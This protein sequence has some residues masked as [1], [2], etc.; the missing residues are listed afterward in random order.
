MNGKLMGTRGEDL[1]GILG[2]VSKLMGKR[3]ED[4]GGEL[5]LV[6]KLMGTTEEPLELLPMQGEAI[7]NGDGGG[8]M[9]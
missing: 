4:L 2:L 1:G 5:G 9:T 7:D 3:G 6:S 8:Y